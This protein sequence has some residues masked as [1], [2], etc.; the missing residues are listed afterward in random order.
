M[1]APP[2]EGGVAAADDTKASVDAAMSTNAPVLRAIR[3][4][5]RFDKHNPFSFC[6]YGVSCRARAER[7]RYAGESG[8]SPPGAG[9]APMGSPL[10][11]AMGARGL[12]WAFLCR[13][14]SLHDT[15]DKRHRTRY[16]LP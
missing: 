11:C 4:M 3:S 5:S 12:G 1:L 15:H 7:V 2:E 14:G 16:R 8:D 13:R 9:M 6:A 10:P